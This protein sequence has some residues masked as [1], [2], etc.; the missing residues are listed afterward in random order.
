[1]ISTESY[2]FSKLPLAIVA[3]FTFVIAF[4]LNIICKS[5]LFNL[6]LEIV[7]LMQQ[8]SYL[9]SKGFIY[10]MNI[11]STILDPTYFSAYI[12]IFYLISYRKM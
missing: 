1:M 4:V 7:P 6:N 3:T 2:F 5:A 9:G 8:N 10:F 11:V 12:L